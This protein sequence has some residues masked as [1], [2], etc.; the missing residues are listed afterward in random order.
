MAWG[1]SLF[2]E[3]R[4]ILDSASGFR[5]QKD[6]YA[7]GNVVQAANAVAEI[8]LGR[9]L[10]IVERLFIHTLQ[11]WHSG[12]LAWRTHECIA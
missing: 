2:H 12:R 1:I 3:A 9:H 10:V 8:D 6:F 5:R 4:P 11:L 7:Y